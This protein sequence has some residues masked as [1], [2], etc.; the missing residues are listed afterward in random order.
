MKEQLKKAALLRTAFNFFLT[1][2]IAPIQ[3]MGASE[4][5]TPAII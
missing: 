4:F 1:L 5:L 2:P 3:A